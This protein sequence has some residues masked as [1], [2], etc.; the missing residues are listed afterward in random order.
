MQLD[1]VLPEVMGSRVLSELLFRGEGPPW[2]CSRMDQY[3]RKMRKPVGGE[4]HG[5]QLAGGSIPP[6]SPSHS[7]LDSDLP[8]ALC[9]P[10]DTGS[11]HRRDPRVT[12]DTRPRLPWKEVM[13]LKK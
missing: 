3:Q 4:G 10:L 1:E 2:A 6:T 9:P 11:R 7:H 5:A 8:P 12:H 13:M